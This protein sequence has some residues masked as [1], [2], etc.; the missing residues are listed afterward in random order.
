MSGLLAP[1]LLAG[2]YGRVILVAG[3]IAGIVLPDMAAYLAGHI[4]PLVALLLFLAVL[5][6]GP[7]AASGAVRGL[8]TSVAMVLFLQCVLPVGLALVLAVMGLVEAPL[9]VATILMLAA[10]PLSGGPHIVAMTGHDST[11]ALRLMVVGVALLPLTV[12]PVFYF[13]PSLGSPLLVLLAALKLLGVILFAAV[14]ATLVRK[15]IPARHERQATQLIDGIS[16]ITMAV[17][18]VGLMS[19]VGPVLSSE[20]LRFLAMLAY[21]FALNFGLQI[22]A[23]LGARAGGFGSATPAIGVM[24]GNRNMALFLTVLP[25]ET[26]DSLLFFLGCAQIPIYLTAFMLHGFYAKMAP[27]A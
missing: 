12:I 16:A 18:V 6:V 27:A 3:I 25:P 15:A 13:V 24:S 7:Q 8:R 22:L 4:A 11:P 19:R 20:P 26:T 23:S 17:V 14:A 1:I 5:R 10:A 9:A 21:V 2:R